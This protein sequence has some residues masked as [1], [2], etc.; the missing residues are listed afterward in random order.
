VLG[1]LEGAVK[2]VTNSDNTNKTDIKSERQ[3]NKTPQARSDTLHAI[4]HKSGQF[5]TA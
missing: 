5:Q 1:E 2:G 3:Q 4:L